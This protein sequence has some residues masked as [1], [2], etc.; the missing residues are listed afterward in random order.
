[1][2]IAFFGSSLVS[3]YWNGAATYYRGI[4]RALAERGHRI[5]FYEPDAFER[6]QHR[7]IADPEWATVVVYPPTVEAVH[8]MLERARSADLVVKASGVGVHDELLERLVIDLKS[9]RTM[10]AFWD[11]DAPATLDRLD[12]DPADPFHALVSRYD[13]VFTYGGGGPVV[14]AYERHGAK[15]CVPIYNAL[16]PSTHFPV[17][18]E[19]RFAAALGFLG[20][21][22]PDREKRVEEFFLRAASLLSDQRF[23]LGG[24]GWHDKLRPDNIA[25]LGHVYTHDHNAFNVSPLAILNVSRDS[26]AAYGFSPATRVFEAA[27]AAACVITDAWEGLE[28]F[29]EPGR[30]VVVAR[31]GVEVAQ[32]VDRLTPDTARVIGKRAHQRMLREHTYAHRALDVEAALGEHHTAR[33]S[34]RRM[35]IVVLGLSITSSWGNG[36]ATTY[37]GL[38]RE[39]SALGHEVLFLERDVPWYAEHRDLVKP[40]YARTALYSSLADLHDRFAREVR[41]ADLVIVGSYVPNGIA[42]GRWVHATARGA[43][44]FYDIDTPVTLARL[45]SGECE[46]LDRDLL[47]RYSLYLSFTGGPTLARISELG[48]ACARPLYCSVDPSLYGPDSRAPRWDLGYMGTYSDDR[49]PVLQRLLIEPAK[50]EPQRSFVVA[51]AQYP[52]WIEWPRN[53]ERIEHL[54]PDRHRT[55]YNELRFTLNV[56]RRDMVAAGWSPSVRLF[57]A[58]ACGVPIISDVWDGLDELFTPGAEILIAESTEDVRRYLRDVRDDKRREIGARACSR[59]LAA[60]TAAHRA[61]DLERYVR[62]LG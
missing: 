36:H 34:K 10:I 5:T 35:S 47:K 28:Q 55:F 37:R 15:R 8:A 4:I 54:V 59:V 6:Q 9:P 42:I 13:L 12:R 26:M 19:P 39:L 11:V 29:L 41:D 14:A 57:E 56:T 62:E 51:G 27:G 52:P 33:S 25:Y 45:A 38:I 3:A 16:D 48:A 24:A 50:Y 31:D 1:M 17:P 2:N 49:Q 53:V 61:A 46:Y 23:L 18:M 60:H 7:D 58:A 21:R 44:A 43:T 32:H 30:E 20:N 22:L 40:P